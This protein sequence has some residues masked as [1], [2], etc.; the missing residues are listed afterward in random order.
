AG[1]PAGRSPKDT[2][3]TAASDDEEGELQVRGPLLS[4]L[5]QREDPVALEG[6]A[7]HVHADAQ[8][9]GLSDVAPGVRVAV[10]LEVE[11][12]RTGR[13]GPGRAGD[14]LQA[15]ALD[16]L[17]VVVLDPGAAAE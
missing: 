16:A 10:D 8:G 7:G 11:Q 6:G 13:Q 5:G 12:P 14:R 3:R 17:A 2:R 4:R 9:V 1:G 15:E